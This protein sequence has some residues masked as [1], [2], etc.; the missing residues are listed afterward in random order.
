MKTA[1]RRLAEIETALADGALYEPDRKG[2]LRELLER[3]GRHK[4]ELD[5]A[6]TEWLNVTQE[7]E[8][9]KKNNDA[10]IVE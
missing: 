9:L 5:A 4:K 2:D 10:E 8:L 1:Q 7:L 6:E 3:Q